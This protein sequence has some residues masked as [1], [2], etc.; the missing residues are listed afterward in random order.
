M[1]IEQYLWG[2]SAEGE[3]ILL[4]TMRCA[5][6]REVRLTNAGAAVTGIYVPGHEKTA[7]EEP[8]QPTTRK[9]GGKPDE[10]MPEL[11]ALTPVF[12]TPEALLADYA[13]CGKTLCGNCYGFGRRIWESRVETNR[14]VMELAADDNGLPAMAVL[15]DLDDDGQ[16]VITHLAKGATTIPFTM[17]TRLF[18]RGAWRAA[19]HVGQSDTGNTGSGDFSAMPVADS[20]TT[21]VEGNLR[22][23]DGTFY[24][25]AGWRKNILGEAAELEETATGRMVEILS[26]QPEVCTLRQGDMLAVVCGE[27]RPAPLDGS[28]FYC[29]KTVYRF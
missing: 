15:F 27:S 24:P 19:L 12:E 28:G 4:Y 23:N 26:S 25:V 11:I 3:G 14:V 8:Q 5:D 17:T 7:T 22:L 10:A 2:A 1:E 16:F 29:Q 18:W 20:S 13:D 9:E 21:G 6:G